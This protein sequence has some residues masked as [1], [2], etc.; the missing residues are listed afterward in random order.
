MSANAY[1]E[2][3][4][5]LQQATRTPAKVG[6]H[7]TRFGRIPGVA[8]HGYVFYLKRVRGQTRLFCTP[9]KKIPADQKTLASMQ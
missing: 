8:S 3:A 6:N 4:H 5:Q 2:L 1:A 7:Y 9:E